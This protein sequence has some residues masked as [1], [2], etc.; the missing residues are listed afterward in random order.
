[1]NI[2]IY[3]IEHSFE[4]K[5]SQCF[6]IEYVNSQ[7]TKENVNRKQM[8]DLTKHEIFLSPQGIVFLGDL[9]GESTKDIERS[10]LQQTNHI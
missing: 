5:V 1:M 4:S 6:N 10:K 7:T 3:W 8:R 2:K 9:N